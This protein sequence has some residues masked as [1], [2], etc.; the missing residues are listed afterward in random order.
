MFFEKL[1]ECI[2]EDL[3][4]S[5]RHRGGCND[6]YYMEIKLIKYYREYFNKNEEYDYEYDIYDYISDSDYESDNED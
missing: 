1:K 5:F 2:G 6:K 4:K 3:F